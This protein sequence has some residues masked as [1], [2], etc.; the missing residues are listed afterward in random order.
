MID[1]DSSG[2]AERFERLATRMA[3][4][5]IPAEAQARAFGST[6]LTAWAALAEVVDKH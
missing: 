3:L 2:L 1:L 6:D 4:L 5:E